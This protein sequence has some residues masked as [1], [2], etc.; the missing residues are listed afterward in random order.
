MEAYSTPWKV[1]GVCAK[2]DINRPIS[3]SLRDQML[4][5]FMAYGE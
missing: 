5:G 1:K 2:L 3:S 4:S